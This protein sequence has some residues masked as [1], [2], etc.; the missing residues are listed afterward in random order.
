MSIK[1]KANPEQES[2]ALTVVQSFLPV[3]ASELHQVSSPDSRLPVLKI[4]NGIEVDP[5]KGITK[6]MAGML[7]L[8]DGEAYSIVPK[9]ALLTVLAARDSV[10]RLEV[11]VDG[12]KVPYAQSNPAHA[13]LDKSYTRA[14]KQ[15]GKFNKSHDLFMKNIND[16][17]FQKGSVYLCAL[18]TPEGCAIVELPAYKVQA[19]YWYR[20]LAQACLH[21]SK[22]GVLLLENDHTNNLKASKADSS[23]K[24]FDPSR[25]T[26]WKIIELAQ[27]QMLQIGAAVEAKKQ[28][29]DGW[30]SK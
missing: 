13:K 30:F 28:D 20:P 12:V 25:F 6:D 14:Y 1:V 24:Y 4:I 22:M 26:Q 29:V 5:S 21:P 3:Q 11:E 10:R 9:N 17:S 23:H 16:E 7:C 15:I 19:S 2:S 8:V 27:E 18:I